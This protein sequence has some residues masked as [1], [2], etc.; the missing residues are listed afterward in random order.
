MQ[1]E[2]N[3]N[4]KG[5]TANMKSELK[6][7][8]WP[9]GKQTVKSTFVTIFF[10]AIISIILILL[11]FGF[12]LLSSGYYKLIFGT[13]DEHKHEAVVSGDVSGDVSGEIADLSGEVSGEVTSGETSTDS[14]EETVVE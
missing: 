2:E 12:D 1:N 4:S 8:V 9:T 3:K 5:F 13:T 6:K 10:V 7:V 11:N 14:G